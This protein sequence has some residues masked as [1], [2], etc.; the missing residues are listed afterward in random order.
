MTNKGYIRGGKRSVGFS[1]LARAVLLLA[2]RDATAKHDTEARRGA[3]RFFQDSRMLVIYCG[4]AEWDIDYLR[5]NVE[6]LNDRNASGV[7]D[8]KAR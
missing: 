3:C 8:G 1:G 7:Q 4:L 5:D 2:V 6:R